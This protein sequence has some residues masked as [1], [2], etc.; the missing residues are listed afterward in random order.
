MVKSNIQMIILKLTTFKK[1][2]LI[3]WVV[4]IHFFKPLFIHRLKV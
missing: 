4:F 1:R 2:L 3:N